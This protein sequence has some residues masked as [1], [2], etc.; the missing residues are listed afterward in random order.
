MKRQTLNEEISRMKNMMRK[1]MNESITP[2]FDKTW[3]NFKN[4]FS[5]NSDFT[6]DKDVSVNV[7]DYKLE[8]GGITFILKGN[9][10]IKRNFS[11]YEQDN[12]AKHLQGEFII[13]S[14]VKDMNFENLTSGYYKYYPDLTNE[15]WGLKSLFTKIYDKNIKKYKN[16]NEY[17]F[18][19]IPND[20]IILIRWVPNNET[21]LISNSLAFEYYKKYYLPNVEN[22]NHSEIENELDSS[23]EFLNSQSTRSGNS[24]AGKWESFK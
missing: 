10:D 11:G 3:E 20:G 4:W 19:Y 15:N 21:N 6:D 9:I 2:K 16:N 7:N 5:T 22:I 18:D 8:I 14:V 13:D 12:R 17:G 23:L 24:T 1:L